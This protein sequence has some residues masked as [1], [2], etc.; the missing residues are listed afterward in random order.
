LVDQ[1]D[2][3]KIVTGIMWF[4]DDLDFKY[5][6]SSGPGGQNVNKGVY[7]NFFFIYWESKLISSWADP[8]LA[9][10]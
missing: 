3:F 5:S 2:G 8:F 9:V 7:R 10:I 1:H 4:S 6:R